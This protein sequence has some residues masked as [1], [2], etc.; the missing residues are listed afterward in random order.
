MNYQITQMIEASKHTCM[1]CEYFDKMPEQ[2]NYP[3][4]EN[5]ACSD[6]VSKYED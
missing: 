2:C 4:A 6:F 3:K 1:E 5:T